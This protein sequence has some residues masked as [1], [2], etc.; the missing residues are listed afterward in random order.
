MWETRVESSFWG[1]YQNNYFEIT[2]LIP[3]IKIR[4]SKPIPYGAK[5]CPVLSMATQRENITTNNRVKFM[6]EL[7]VYFVFLFGRRV[8]DLNSGVLKTKTVKIPER[9]A[10]RSQSLSIISHQLEINLSPCQP[11]VVNHRSCRIFR[12]DVWNMTCIFPNRIVYNSNI[13]LIKLGL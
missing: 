7:P 9:L 5:F 8:V 13:F 12:A 3:G 1:Q 6:R 10:T 11:Y 2:H 4:V